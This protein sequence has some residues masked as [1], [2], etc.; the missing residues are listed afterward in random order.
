[1]DFGGEILQPIWTPGHANDHYCILV[2]NRGWLFSGDLFISARPKVTRRVESPLIE[3]DSLQKLLK[4]DFDLLLC[5]HRGPI[6]QG[7]EAIRK[8]WERLHEIKGLAEDLQKKGWSTRAITTELLGKEDLLLS[9][10]SLGD[11][12]KKNLIEGLLADSKL[13]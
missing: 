5:A 1:M 9:L 4:H 3:M 8:K 7:K 2:P 10:I 12:S 6:S 11:F 13:N